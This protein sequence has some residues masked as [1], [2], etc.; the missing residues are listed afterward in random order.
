[1]ENLKQIFEI[2]IENIKE[3]Q[4]EALKRA[5]ISRLTHVIALLEAGSYDELWKMLGFSASGDGYGCEN[6]Y[7]D[8]KDIGESINIPDFGNGFD[9][10]SMISFLENLK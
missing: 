5:I 6:H 4:R 8:F 1:M 9:I 10:G 2:N 3:K 7:I